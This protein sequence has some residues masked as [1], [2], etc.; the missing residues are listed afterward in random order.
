M[1]QKILPTLILSQLGVCDS[2]Y[3]QQTLQGFLDIYMLQ[4]IACLYTTVN[5][6]P[7]ATNIQKILQEAPI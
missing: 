2:L 4:F 5:N 3:L 6:L 7:E 1:A